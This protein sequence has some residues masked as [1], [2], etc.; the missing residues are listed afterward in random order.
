LEGCIITLAMK[1]VSIEEKPMH[2]YWDWSV[3]QP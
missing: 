2:R 3:L 1:A